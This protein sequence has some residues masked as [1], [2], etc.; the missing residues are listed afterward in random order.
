M[1]N[2]LFPILIV[3]GVGIYYLLYFRRIKQL[4]GMKAAGEVYWREQ[5]GLDVGEKVVS[6]GV[7]AFYMG[8]L[9]PESERSTGDKVVDFLT[10]TTWRGANVFIAFTSGERFGIAVEETEDGPKGVQTSLGLKGYGRLGVWGP[11]ERLLF[12]TAAEAWP[13]SP[14]LPNEGQKPKRQ[15][16][17]GGTVR[18]ELVRLT[19]PD[20][21][22]WALFIEPAWV[23]LMRSWSQ[24]GPAYVDPRYVDAPA[25]KM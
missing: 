22:S 23:P 20:G 13:G 1:I 4:G 8:P 12:Q 10:N 16:L 5:F 17:T 19:S 3:L 6:M 18:M 9:V 2:Y 15:A 21:Q 24:G 11:R 25:Y 7:G 14:H